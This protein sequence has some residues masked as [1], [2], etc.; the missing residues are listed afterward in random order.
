MFTGIVQHLGVVQAVEPRGED[1]RLLVDTGDWTVDDLKIG[2]SI[3]V[4][5]ACL[6]VVERLEHGFAADVSQE[7]LR[8]TTLGGLR[9]GAAMNLEKPLTLAAPLGGHLMLGHIDG[10]GRVEAMAKEARSLRLTF[11]VP[12]ALAYYVAPKGSVSIDGVS[13]TVNT[14]DDASFTVNIIPHTLERTAIKCY[15]IG[16]TVNIE[17][18]LMARYLERLMQNDGKE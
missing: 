2:D 15:V 6:T 18:D 3:A 17:V 7:T 8:L 1:A 10:I 5:G 14:V 13:L 9:P 12:Q 4:S 16:T 11:S